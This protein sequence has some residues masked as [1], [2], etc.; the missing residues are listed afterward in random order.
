MHYAIQIESIYTDYL[1]S[2]ARKKS[3][4]ANFLLVEQGMILFRV[5]RYEYAVE[6]QQSIWIPLHCLHS[7]TLL[8]G[9]QLTRIDFS[10][11]LNAPFPT[12]AGYVQPGPLAL[13][14]LKR[15]KICSRQETVFPHLTAVFQDEALSFRPQLCK[16]RLTHLLCRW[17]PD[18]P[19]E[20][21]AP[22][23]HLALLLRTARKQEL[24][25]IKPEV[26]AKRWFN[27]DMKQY[28]QL[29]RNI[30]GISD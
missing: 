7:L 9:T 17:Q 12:Q 3:F 29:R 24:S 28:R 11:R 1:V 16:S 8:P 19:V 5:G 18:R 15:L 21:L 13:Q 23:I 10:A 14:I 4:K 27:D 2:T 20:D 22:E 26:V 30:L 6:P 25:G